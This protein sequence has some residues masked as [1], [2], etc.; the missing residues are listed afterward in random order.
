MPHVL[1]QKAVA[2]NTLTHTNKHHR[3]F[4]QN[5]L[6]AF[7][8]LSLLLFSSHFNHHGAKNFSR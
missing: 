7:L 6:S 4:F 8:A 5:L 3:A 1:R 2:V